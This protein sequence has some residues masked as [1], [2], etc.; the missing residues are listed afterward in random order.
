M[1]Y[2]RLQVKRSFGIEET[3]DLREARSVYAGDDTNN[4]VCVETTDVPGRIQVVS[5]GK[6]PRIKLTSEVIPSLNGQVQKKKDWKTRLY[7]GADFIAEGETSW[8]IGDAEF[9]LYQVEKLALTD[10]TEATDPLERKHRWQSIGTSAGMHVAV[11]LLFFVMSLIMSALQDREEEKL[12]AQKYDIAKVQDLF[13]VKPPEPSPTPA[14][15]EP[16][17][18][19][20]KPKKAK[21]AN[22]K[23]V[24]KKKAPR[25]ASVKRAA[26][27]PA[28]QAAVAKGKGAKKKD[29]KSMGLLAIQSANTSTPKE[30]AL[31]IDKPRR[32][33]QVADADGI[34]ASASLSKLGQGIR[35]GVQK[36][37]VATLNGISGSGYKPGELA[38]SVA[39]STGPSIQLVRKEVEI[40][41]GLD[42]AIIQQI[43][44]ERLAEVRYCYETALLK[45]VDLSGKISTSW[46]IQPDGTVANLNSSSKDIKENAL[47]N[48]VR[49]RINQWRFPS[50]KG[51]GV[52]HVKYPFVFSSLG[53]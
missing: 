18:E 20:P 36:Q 49:E 52:V 1:K 33:Q 31:N 43:I 38:K 15:V 13:K 28:Q 12:E 30:R 6:H 7:T 44:Q 34:A 3:F 24:A 27:K 9:R 50:P 37:R 10:Y 47:H 14:K 42:P 25:K 23:Q 8:K 4:E 39:A 35:T 19:Q 45:K 51:G 5:A 21:K 48:C 29:L 40:R 32:V 46:T 22:K 16:P 26:Q 41:G 11:A 53:S 2:W 17:K